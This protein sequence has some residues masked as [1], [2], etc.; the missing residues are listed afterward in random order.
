MP[1]PRV[2]VPVHYEGWSHFSEP[3]AHARAALPDATWLEPGMA[4]EV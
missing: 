1:D 2:V 3:E 4:T